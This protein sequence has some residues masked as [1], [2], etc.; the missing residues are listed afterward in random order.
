MVGC[1]CRT[2]LRTS[3]L[4][5]ILVISGCQAVIVRI[6]QYTIRNVH[7]NNEENRN[8]FLLLETLISNFFHTFMQPIEV[9]H[10]NQSFIRPM[11]N[12]ISTT[13]LINDSIINW[14]LSQ[15]EITEELANFFK[16]PY[17]P[18]FIKANFK[19]SAKIT[20]EMDEC[21]RDFTKL[22]QSTTNALLTATYCRLTGQN[23]TH[24]S[25]CL[26]E[27]LVLHEHFA[28]VLDAWGRPPA[29]L[30]SSGP[31]FWLGDYDQC[32]RISKT[33]AANQSVQ[34]CRANIR[35][36]AYGIEF[37]QIP[38]FYGMCLPVRCNEHSI[39]GI[40]PVLSSFLERTFGISIS[41]KSEVEC[42]KRSDTFFSKLD[43]QQWTIIAF[44][45][46]LV[47]LVLCG[48]FI[49][50]YRKRR[51]Q[52]YF[53]NKESSGSCSHMTA[54]QVTNISSQMSSICTPCVQDGAYSF[55][56]SD[57]PSQALTYK[58]I[59]AVRR[60]LKKSSCITN[61]VLAF[62]IL[63]TYCYLTRPRNRHLNS[64]HGLRVLSA[65]WVVIGHAHLF[66]LDYI[67]NVRQFWSLLKANENFSQLIF[68]SSLS[69]DSFLLLS[70]TVLAY[71][72]H[73]RL[74][75]QKRRKRQQ[76]VLSP[77][78]LLA[79]WLHRFTRLMPAYLITFLI[80][81]FVF[82][83]IGDGP[84]WSQQNGIFGARCS[85]DDIWRQLLFVSNFYPN[86][87]MPWMWYLAL[88]TQCYII[89]P[90]AL[91]LLH[92]APTV[93]IILT[94]ATIVLSVIYRATVIVLFRFPLT[95]I[96]AIVENDSLT[97]ELMEK[98]FR[99]LYAVPH[100]RIGSF[101]IG[102]FLGWSLSTK[103]K[104]TH[105][106]TQIDI[107]RFASILMIAFS[108]FG[109]SY[110]N[111]FTAFSVFY[112]STFRVF[113]TFGLALFVWLCERG[114]MNMIYAFLA[115]KKWTF[116]SRLSYGFYLSHE[117]ILL[118]FI[119]T[120]RSPI[121][122]SSAY[123]FIVVAIEISLLSLLASFLIAFI[124]EIPPLIIE[125]KLFKTIRTRI[126]PNQTC[127]ENKQNDQLGV[128]L[129]RQHKHDEII[130][131]APMIPPMKRT[132]RW[133]E[134]NHDDLKVS[135]MQSIDG[136]DS[137]K[138][139]YYTDTDTFDKKVK[140]N[141]GSIAS[142]TI[143]TCKS[144]SEKSG[145]EKQIFKSK[146][147]RTP[148][149]SA[150]TMPKTNQRASDTENFV[151][152]VGTTSPPIDKFV[153]QQQWETLI[154]QNY[155]KQVSPV[156]NIGF[157]WI[158]EIKK[159]LDIERDTHSQPSHCKE[160]S[161]TQSKNANRQEQQHSN[162]HP[163]EEQISSCSTDTGET[164]IHVVSESLGDPAESYS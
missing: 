31:F 93:A 46:F 121:M 90:I 162:I 80:I 141:H 84:M 64:L 75:Q 48:T 21:L 43:I 125:R 98:M 24:I 22:I 2:A 157:S 62:S 118:Y 155:D 128:Q 54:P 74:K 69:V 114:H 10:M 101:L 77:C 41:N 76:T 68:N 78:G 129:Y 104:Q 137:R 3:C 23:Q 147:V 97:I 136:V 94:V 131:L 65:F 4:I 156:E 100:A 86:E 35:V 153:K 50:A 88:D 117:P 139:Q 49:D 42:F 133:I 111:S 160:R 33:T 1:S 47:L 142:G 53:V 63:S 120:R 14:N 103:S 25:Q 106:T 87:C 28:Q 72:V 51:N 44:L 8:D 37:N 36:E 57:A 99:H 113:W 159:R 29:G 39:N 127:E 61:I 119:W 124:I 82:Q 92:I 144:L 164:I 58:N 32:Q 56:Y 27:H 154:K 18:T 105:S 138:R 109:A 9:T 149:S 145:N 95:L 91:I 163:H 151:H 143:S 115:W 52:K 102:I 140:K 5:L 150:E 66:S 16:Q 81:Y 135:S 11:E 19:K 45:A 122:P 7:G 12:E 148:K 83:Q 6:S 126:A 26:D 71:K 59:S 123:H 34:Y 132:E 107:A 15:T 152:Q 89:A 146:L 20:N 79:L 158:D 30:Y 13:T 112:A 55:I 73:L 161:I 85:T 67:G 40:F 108:L 130:E 110:A 38:I 70:A 60:T 17:F 96:S 116:F 134:E